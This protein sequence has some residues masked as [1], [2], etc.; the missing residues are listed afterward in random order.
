MNFKYIKTLALAGLVG[1]GFS[2][3]EDFLDRP[4]KD[5][6][7]SSTFYQTDDQCYS[8]VNYLYNMPWF[9]VLRGYFQVEVLAGNLYMGDSPYL[10]YMVDGDTEDNVNMSNS[11]WAVIANTNTVYDNIKNGNGSEAAK[12]DCMGQCLLWKA[13]AYFYIVRTYGDVPLIHN[14]MDALGQDYNNFPKVQK[15]DIYEYIIM[16]LEKAQELLPDTPKNPGRFC[17]LTADALM[18]KVYLAKAGVTGQLNQADLDA[19]ADHALKVAEAKDRFN[20]LPNYSDN[21]RL[22]YNFNE[23]SIIAWRWDCTTDVWTTQN[24]LQSDLAWSGFDEWNCWGDWRCISVDL[25]EAFGIK[26]L[27]QQPSA[28]LGHNDTRLKATMMLPGF[29]YDYFWTDHALPDG[30][31]NG[32]DFLNFIYNKEYNSQAK[33]SYD[34][35]SGASN[36]K[37]L[38]GDNAD[39]RAGVGYAPSGQMASSLATHI[40]RLAD[41]YLIYAEAKLHGPGSTTNDPKAIELYRAVRQRALSTTVP[42]MNSLKWEDVWKERRLELAMEGDRWYDYV[43]VSYYNPSFVENELKNQKREVYGSIDKLTREYYSTGNWTV[44]TEKY[45]ERPDPLNVGRLQVEDYV[46]KNKVLTIPMPTT[47]LNTNAHLRPEAASEHVDVREKY[48]Y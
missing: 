28:W 43:R 37:H 35:Q 9:D 25:Q 33:D 45:P 44:T 7:T 4:T 16:T 15:A 14:N 10:K 20:L 47:D 12:K 6:D 24:C 23:E 11:L 39:H 38:H 36:V 29:T 18:A 19:A 1:L 3:C 30:S 2:S 41:V 13:M 48:R 46:S 8:G 22:Q 40:L 17:K 31:G 32:F 27:E 21:F 5:T 26:I 42:E 34:A